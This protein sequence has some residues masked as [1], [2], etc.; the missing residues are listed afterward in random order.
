MEESKIHSTFG[1]ATQAEISQTGAELERARDGNRSAFE[2]LF[3]R[4]S[5]IVETHVAV[6][7]RRLGPALCAKIEAEDVAQDVMARAWERLNRFEYRGQGSL[8][9]WLHTMTEHHLKN[10]IASWKSQGKDLGKE[11]SASQQAETGSGISGPAAS[12]PGPAT[13][14]HE[15]EQRVR[16]VA[17]LASLSER[18]RELLERKYVM[19]EDWDEIARALD[20][21]SKDAARMDCARHAL[22]ALNKAL[23]AARA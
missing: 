6:R 13:M 15:E 23:R 7:L 22:P 11:R 17:A 19:G 5:I 2:R 3:R 12:G 1:T 16:V 10:R 20:Y 9:A 4:F 21:P 14:A 18:P 8:R